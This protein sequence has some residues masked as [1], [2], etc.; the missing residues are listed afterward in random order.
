MTIGEKIK[1]IRNFR[2]MTQRELGLAVGFDENTAKN[3]IT[4]YENGYRTPKKDML[5]KLAKALN[6]NYINFYSPCPG[7]AEDI[8]QLFFWL[9]EE[10]SG[11]IRLFQLV[12]NSDR[13]PSTSI[14]K[15]QY[16][17]DLFWPQQ[18]PVGMYF[19]YPIFDDFLQEWLTRQEELDAGK[20]THDEYFEWKLNWPSTCDDYIGDDSY[21]AWRKE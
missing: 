10:R 17:D 13:C 14:A 11:C 15:A 8:L 1:R 6:V 3:R 5:D 4:L 20:I 19:K 2:G 7:C 12:R 18:P 16:D 9:D 21:F